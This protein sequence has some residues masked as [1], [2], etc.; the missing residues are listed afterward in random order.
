MKLKKLFRVKCKDNKMKV[1]SDKYHLI[2]NRNNQMEIEVENE[3]VKS[4]KQKKLLGKKIDN[5]LIVNMHVDHLCKKLVDKCK[6]Q[7]QLYIKYINI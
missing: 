3:H 1:N 5:D 4:K 7:R 2:I 6:N